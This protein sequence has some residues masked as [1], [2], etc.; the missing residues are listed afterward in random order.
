MVLVFLGKYWW[1]REAGRLWGRAGQGSIIHLT[2]GARSAFERVYTKSFRFKGQASDCD[3]ST[4]LH[5]SNS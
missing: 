5:N 4:Y 1:N 3:N 2:G